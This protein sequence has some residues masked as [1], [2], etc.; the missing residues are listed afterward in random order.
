MSHRIRLVDIAA[1]CGVSKAAVVQALN[2]PP[3]TCE[4]RAATRTRIRAAAARL[5]YRP[6]WRARALASGRTSTVGLLYAGMYPPMGGYP[7][8]LMGAIARRLAERGI[9][10]L[11]LRCW[12]A[13]TWREAVDERR[14]DGAVVLDGP[15]AGLLEAGPL[16]VPLVLANI[17]TTLAVPQVLPDDHGGAMIA[18]RRLVALGHRRIVH[19]TGERRSGHISA[20]SRHDGYRAAMAEAGL[21]ARILDRTAAL[22]AQ[23]DGRTP[24]SAV[25]AYD[26]DLAIQAIR[27]A[28]RRGLRV[29]QDLAVIGTNDGPEA[30][31][32]SPALASVALPGDPLAFAAADLLLG[33]IAGAEPPGAP[34]LL[35]ETLVERASLGPPG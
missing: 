34:V 24:P 11:L 12:E 27:L 33:L 8:R 25:H 35:P 4:L 28:Q 32:C 29:P 3:E 19:L 14:I 16:P 9:G 21:P 31:A 22:D 20:Q 13:S 17:A 2:R 6:D 30:A 7:A 10:L 23:L 18:V 26:D 1:A 15:P 5:G